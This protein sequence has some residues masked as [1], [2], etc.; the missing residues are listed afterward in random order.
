MSNI[1]KTIKENP[2]SFGNDFP[3]EIDVLINL[4]KDSPPSGPN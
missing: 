4:G 2:T 1:G 3:Q